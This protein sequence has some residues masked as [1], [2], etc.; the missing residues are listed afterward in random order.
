MVI[1]LACILAAL[2]PGSGDADEKP[3]AVERGAKKVVHAIN[4]ASHRAQA[5]VERAADRTGKW[6]ERTGRRASNTA[7]RTA[8]KAETWIR[9]VDRVVAAA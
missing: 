8:D 4:H 9:K 1:A 7:V 3:S 5:G 2:P 6:A